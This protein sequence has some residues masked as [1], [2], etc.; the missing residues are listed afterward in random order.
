V[1]FAARAVLFVIWTTAA[2]AT[3]RTQ[4]MGSALPCEAVEDS[5]RTSVEARLLPGVYRLVMVATGG[6]A[7]GKRAEGRLEL[8]RTALSDRSPRTGAGPER[9]DTGMTPLYGFSDLDFGAVG[10]SLSPGPEIPAPTSRDPIYPG[11]LAHVQ[12]WGSRTH[13]QQ[14][15]LT[16][17]TQSNVRAKLAAVMVDGPGAGLWVRRLWADR[18]EGTW[19]PWGRGG[20]WGYFCA[21]RLTEAR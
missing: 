8:R 15:A 11:L 19:R 3:A 6:P 16:V 13:P 5:L 10:V 14:N 21:V 17:G 4:E 7:S 2:A 1:G 9:A 20:G 12:N 18:F